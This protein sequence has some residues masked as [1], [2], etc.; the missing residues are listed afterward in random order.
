MAVR[1]TFDDELGGPG[2]QW[3]YCMIDGFSAVAVKNYFVT[4]ELMLRWARSRGV[5]HER[6]KEWA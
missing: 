6:I 3:D 4:M 5:S 2:C 1:P